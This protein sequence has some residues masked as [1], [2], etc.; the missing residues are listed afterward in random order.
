MK[1]YFSGDKIEYPAPAI[2]LGNFDGVHSGH[3]KIIEQARTLGESFGVLLFESHTS[4]AVGDAV[5]VITPLF[6]KLKIL[7]ELCVDFVYLVS[8][9]K[10]I[11]NMSCARFCE[12]LS[13]IG[14][15]GVSV[16]YD[17]KF[18]KNAAGDA[19]QLKSLLA[20]Y[21]IEVVVSDVVEVGGIAVKSSQIRDLVKAGDIVAAN[22]LMTRP[23]RLSGL[24]TSGF[25]N[26]R[27]M[28][29]PTANL[30]PDA[31]I[32]LPGD[33]VYYGRCTVDDNVY[34]AVIN[35][36]KNPTFNAETRTVEAHIIGYSDDLYGYRIELEFL[37][38]IRG[39]MRFNSI[40]ELKKQIARDKEYAQNCEI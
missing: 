15:F 22:R 6:E 25:Q 2:A 10:E 20:N 28:G 40:D 32:L 23:L 17:Y 19:A 26:G 27:K 7:S 24:V 36:G 35:V 11:M 4:K 14:I 1:I 8:F 18:G 39:E 31:D 30:T 38:R 21:N 33:G 12:Y 13:K 37:E 9:D 3:L 16:G 29:F 34:R 5:K